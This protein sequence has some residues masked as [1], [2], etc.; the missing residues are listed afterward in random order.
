MDNISVLHV[1][2]FIFNV[3][4]A[5]VSQVMLKKAATKTYS[6]VIREYLNPLVI[7]AYL[8]FFATALIQALAFRGVPLS[9]GSV[10]E[11]TAYV[12]VTAFGVLMFKEKIN[13]ARVAG[14]ALIIA[15]VVVC[16]L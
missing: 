12:Y 8:I 14:L 1:I 13:A 10:L 4:L 11:T 7:C 9:L 16:F 3:F 2:I 6:S 5:A 15:G